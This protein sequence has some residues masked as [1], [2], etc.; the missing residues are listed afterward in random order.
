MKPETTGAC[1]CVRAGGLALCWLG[2]PPLHG[3][4]CQGP[5]DWLGVRAGGMGGEYNALA[6]IC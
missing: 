5:S 3:A 1:S 2:G 4:Q 6:D